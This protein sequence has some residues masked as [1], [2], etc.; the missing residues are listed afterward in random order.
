MRKEMV[1]G[2]GGLIGSFHRPLT[3]YNCQNPVTIMYVRL[4]LKDK[5]LLGWVKGTNDGRGAQGDER[6][7]RKRPL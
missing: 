5:M 2:Q 4:L 7:L 6:A 3:R 1:R